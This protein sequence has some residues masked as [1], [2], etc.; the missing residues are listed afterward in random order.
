MFNGI[1]G[2]TNSTSYRILTAE[3]YVTKRD[4]KISA[5]VQADEKSFAAI[6]HV[7]VEQVPYGTMRYNFLNMGLVVHTI[8][9]AAQT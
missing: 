6:L 1:S 4:L 3:A 9:L 2:K 7:G 8:R 5:S